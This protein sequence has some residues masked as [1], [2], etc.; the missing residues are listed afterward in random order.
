MTHKFFIFLT[1]FLFSIS[2][3]AQDKNYEEWYLKTNDNQD[4]FVKEL[5]T[6]KD[7]I[8]V[9][10]GGFGA[11]HDYMTDITKGLENKYHFIFYDQRGSLLSWVPD[12]LGPT[13]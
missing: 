3:N 2:L 4:I 7:T 8:I 12:S 5:G 6:G 9:V 13:E 11:N 10:H 1:T